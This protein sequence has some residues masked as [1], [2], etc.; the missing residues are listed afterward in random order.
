MIL[1]EPTLGFE[2]KLFVADPATRGMPAHRSDFSHLKV[3]VA[4]DLLVDHD[5][6][7]EPRRLS[8][9]APV[10]VLRHVRDHLGA[11]GAANVARNL[12]ALGCQVGVFGV[13][14]RDD[15]GSRL[16]ELLERESIATSGVLA[17]DGYVTPTKTRVLAA[18]PR[19]DAQQILR[20]DREPVRAVE[21]TDRA[22]VASALRAAAGSLHA[23]VLSDYGYGLV[24]GEIGDV[25]RAIAAAG[26][27]AVLDPRA[28]VGDLGGLTAMTPNLEELARCTGLRPEDLDGRAALAAAARTLLRLAGCRYVL[29]TRDSLGMALFGA[30]LPAQGTFVA[31]SGT[32]R[33]SDVRG[34][35]DTAAAVFALALAAGRS[36]PDAMVLANAAA[37]VVVLEHGAAV[38]GVDELDGALDGAP[39]A[40]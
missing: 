32:E 27:V 28:A 15:A 2:E 9:E 38:C 20:I 11:G 6:Y 40:L 18:E 10:M 4:G 33:I 25:A 21:G 39:M 24:G 23:V 36:A 29:V 8:R 22:T 19:R 31:A 7:A 14:G 13:V 3:A 1:R 5:L 17:I 34:A 37:G 12:R 30:G 26:G 16:L 35:G